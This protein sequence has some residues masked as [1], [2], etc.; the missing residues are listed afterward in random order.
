M[1]RTLFAA[2]VMFCATALSAT[3]AEQAIRFV[4]GGFFPS[5]IY[6]HNGTKL[7]FKNEYTQTARI[8]LNGMV[9]DLAPGAEVTY[10]YAQWKIVSANLM[11]LKGGIVSGGNVNWT[12]TAEIQVDVGAPIWSKKTYTLLTG[13]TN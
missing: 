5:N 12:Q 6:V 10:N 7:H 9:F 13:I 11:D 1:L 4:G 8:S 3:A 2:I